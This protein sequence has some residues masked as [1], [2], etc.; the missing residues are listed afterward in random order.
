MNQFVVYA[1]TCD[2]RRAAAKV[3]AKK[4]KVA[5]FMIIRCLFYLVVGIQVVL[6]LRFC[7][8]QGIAFQRKRAL[9]QCGR[10]YI[11]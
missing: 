10:A 3:H 8:I 2:A 1:D 5:V 6:S 11:Y 7:E 9:S 4:E